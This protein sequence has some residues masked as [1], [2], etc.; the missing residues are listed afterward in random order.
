MFGFAVATVSDNLRISKLEVFSKCE[1]F[2]QTLQGTL[3]QEEVERRPTC[4]PI[5][6]GDQK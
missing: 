3:P 5:Y 6:K 4:C 2:I 1:S